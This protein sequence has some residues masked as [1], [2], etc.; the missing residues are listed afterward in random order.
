MS[1]DLCRG[2]R[3]L[4]ARVSS[5]VEMNGRV[6][7]IVGA[8]GIGIAAYAVL[9]LG[10]S[11][12]VGNRDDATRSRRTRTPSKA[13][14]GPR[15]KRPVAGPSRTEAS[16]P[17]VGPRVNPPVG[18]SDG[19]PRVKPKQP[20]L[21]LEQAREQFDDLMVELDREIKRGEEVG[22]PLSNE[23]WVEYYRRGS[24]AITP[25]VRLI[26]SEDGN[27]QSEINERQTELRERL[28]ALQPAYV[29]P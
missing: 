6:L 9:S 11:R 27:R 18:P 7:A 20:E 22:R 15:P 3:W 19:V 29:Q 16:N 12:Q 1:T 25:I 5:V 2:C 14:A 26:P 23:A 13:D 17:G 4:V 24:E 8:L 21:T 10:G 28:D